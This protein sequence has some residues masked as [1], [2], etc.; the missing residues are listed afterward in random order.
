MLKKQLKQE[1][2]KESRCGG[3]GRKNGDRTSKVFQDSPSFAYCPVFAINNAPFHSQLC[4]SLDNK[5]Y[6]YNKG[7]GIKYIRGRIVRL[8]R[9]IATPQINK[10]E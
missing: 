5:L 6:G 9:R 1:L 7:T 3:G 4:P 10:E 8:D 2:Y